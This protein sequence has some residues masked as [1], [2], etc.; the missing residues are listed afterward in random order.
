MKSM[1]ILISKNLAAH[2]DSNMLTSLIYSLTL[3]NIIFVVVSASVQIHTLSTYPYGLITFQAYDNDWLS[4]QM[5][6]N[7]TVGLKPNNIDPLLHEYS[8]YIEDFGLVSSV[9]NMTESHDFET[10][11]RI[12]PLAVPHDNYKRSLY[13]LSS[14][15]ILDSTF[16]TE[17]TNRTTSLGLTDQL[18]TAAGSQSIALWYKSMDHELTDPAKDL[19]YMKIEPKFEKMKGLEVKN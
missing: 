11:I 8:D 17:Y 13:G 15:S 5:Q 3:G 4:P 6:Y 12:T 19:F 1:K 16:F 7:S 10:K 18:Y 14:S 9:S 2:R